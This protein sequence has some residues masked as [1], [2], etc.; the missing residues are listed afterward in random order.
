MNGVTN[1]LGMELSQLTDDEERMG[2][3][4]GRASVHV[5]GADNRPDAGDVRELFQTPTL[6]TATISMWVV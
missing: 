1:V 5:A 6:R 3:N 2:L 4:I